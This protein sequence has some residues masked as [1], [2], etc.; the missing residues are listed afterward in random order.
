MIGKPIRKN[1]LI[2]LVI[3]NV[4]CMVANLAWWAVMDDSENNL[5][6]AIFGF[7]IVCAL[8]YLANVNGTS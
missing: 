5:I 8:L 1:T 3:A 7:I 2:I 4:V 6:V